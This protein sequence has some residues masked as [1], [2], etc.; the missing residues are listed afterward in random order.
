MTTE[1]LTEKVLRLEKIV[2]QLVPKTEQWVG[3]TVITKATGWSTEDLR[4]YR[5]NGGIKYKV[6]KQGGKKTYAYLL[7]SIPDHL[8]NQ[9]P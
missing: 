4:K 2:G 1:Q 3:A 9:T 8:L 7:S 6:K 5:R